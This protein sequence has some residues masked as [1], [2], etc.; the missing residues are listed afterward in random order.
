MIRIFNLDFMFF[1]FNRL[2]FDS[3]K[4]VV[5]YTM[6]VV[7]YLQVTVLLNSTVITLSLYLGACFF[8]ITLINEVKKDLKNLG[9]MNEIENNFGEI[10]NKFDA[11]IQFHA[12]TKQLSFDTQ[13]FSTEMSSF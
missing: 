2:P 3:S 11:F 4:P 7:Q 8:I 10:K 13:Y 9:E 12:E 6:F 5:F 1:H